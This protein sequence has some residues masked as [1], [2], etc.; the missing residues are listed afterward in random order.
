MGKFDDVVEKM[1]GEMTGKLGMGRVDA[2]LLTAIAKSL[3]PSIYKKDAALVACSD[4]KERETIK[5]KFLIKKLGLNEG[6]ALDNAIQFACEEMGT[7]NRNKYRIIFY[8]I[9]VKKLKKSKVFA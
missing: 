8:Y 7:R 9:L 2:K 6:A 1:K 5:K 4:N 3:G